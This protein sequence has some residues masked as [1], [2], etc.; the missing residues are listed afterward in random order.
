MNDDFGVAMRVELVTTV[1]ELLAQF[2]EIIDFAVKNDPNAA[3]FVV[4]G[5][6]PAGEINDAQPSHPQAPRAK[7]VDTFVVRTTVNDGGAHTPHA[8]RVYGLAVTPNQADY[9]AHRSTA[10][11]GSGFRILRVAGIVARTEIGTLTTCKPGRPQLSKQRRTSSYL[12]L[13]RL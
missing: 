1:H 11:S 6:M 10:C 7:R 9:P 3:I 2:S 13:D 8:G 12:R 5:L 4:N